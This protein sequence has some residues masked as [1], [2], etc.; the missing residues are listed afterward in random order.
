MRSSRKSMNS[1]PLES[2]ILLSKTWRDL[3]E[4]LD[5]ALYQL[6]SQLRPATA[7]TLLAQH[8]LDLSWRV[9][10][11]TGGDSNS[12]QQVTPTTTGIQIRIG[13]LHEH[14]LSGHWCVKVSC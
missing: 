3:L 13:T 6:C 9:L 4:G 7:M 11:Y 1:Q 12:R 2:N 5:K 10:W 8:W 14:E